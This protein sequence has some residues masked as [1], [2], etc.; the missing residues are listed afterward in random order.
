MNKDRT[1]KTDEFDT[2]H[3]LA[4]RRTTD[5]AEC[6]ASEENYLFCPYILFSRLGRLCHHPQREGIIANSERLLKEA[7]AD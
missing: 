5:V 6:L 7:T 4:K 3:C 1:N 2:S